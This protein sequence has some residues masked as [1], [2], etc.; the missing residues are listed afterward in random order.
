MFT[1]ADAKYEKERKYAR[2]MALRLT[3][4]A[5]DVCKENQRGIMSKWDRIYDLVIDVPRH[6]IIEVGPDLGPQYIVYKLAELLGHRYIMDVIYEGE[7]AD[8][9]YKNMLWKY[10]CRHM[11]WTYIH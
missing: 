1:R 3:E 11:E 2:A 4:G 6:S 9:E 8:L 7:S 5:C 10:V